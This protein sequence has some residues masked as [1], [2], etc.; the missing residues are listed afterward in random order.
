[1]PSQTRA[2]VVLVGLIAALVIPRVQALTGVTLTVS[3]VA[4]LSALA[5]VV[6]HGAASTF[7]RY[8]P[9][10][11]PHTTQPAAPAQEIAK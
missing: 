8:F 3:D 1:M 10:P 11:V 2:N 9:P 6:W 4:A 7:E 5:L